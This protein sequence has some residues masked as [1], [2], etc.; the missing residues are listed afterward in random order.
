MPAKPP[1]EESLYEAA[2]NHI[3]RYAAT[4]AGLTRVLSRRIDRWGQ[5]RALEQG[6]DEAELA[7]LSRLAKA[8]I[9]GVLARLKALGALDDSAFAASRARRLTRAGKSRRAT[10]A[11]LAAKGVNQPDL[12]DD[13]DRELA[14]ACAFLRRRRGGA[15]GEAPRDK[16]LAAMAR[17]GFTQATARQALSLPRDE[18][19]QLIKSLENLP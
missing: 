5:K 19:E 15:F 2:M 1:D 13:P 6:A 18:A 4:E 16:L 7:Q 12:P 14:A 10:L 3:A 11:H 9:P 8:A 17:G